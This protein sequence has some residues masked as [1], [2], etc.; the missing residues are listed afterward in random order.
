MPPPARREMDAPRDG[1]L[2]GVPRPRNSLP[3]APRPVA[4]VRRPDSATLRS[5]QSPREPF[6]WLP[7]WQDWVRLANP[8]CRSFPVA[9]Q[10]GR[11]GFVRCI[12]KSAYSG[13]RACVI[14]RK[15]ASFRQSTRFFS[16]R[17]C[18]RT[19]GWEPHPF[20][21]GRSPT[22][23]TELPKNTPVSRM[24]HDFAKSSGLNFEGD[25]S[26]T[27]FNSARPTPLWRPSLL[28]HQCLPRTAGGRP[29]ASW[30]FQT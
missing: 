10:Y 11:N 30:R 7:E 24:A 23:A 18:V 4:R 20:P 12:S 16:L 13:F 8:S 15:L 17:A 29:G 22:T 1:S 14:G 28:L 5:N 27:F 21:P 9:C 26:G 6:I 25:E 19:T 3:D 2:V